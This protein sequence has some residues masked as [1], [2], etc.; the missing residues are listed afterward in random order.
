MPSWQMR[1]SWRRKVSVDTITQATGLIVFVLWF[2]RKSKFVS[3]N[4][5]HAFRISEWNAACTRLSTR[6]NLASTSALPPIPRP[7]NPSG[8]SISGPSASVDVTASNASKRSAPDDASPNEGDSSMASPS[9]K[10]AKLSS[11][12]VSA[13]N[14]TPVEG[15]TAKVGEPASSL[16]AV[17]AVAAAQQQ[18]TA[19]IAL[20]VLKREDLEP[21]K[22]PSQKEMEAALL[23]MRKKMLLDQYGI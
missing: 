14:S 10:E 12:S 18:A 20:N 15:L 7:S 6:L 21:P 23:V 5:G 17:A 16:P 4:V 13:S 19:Y 3:D 11:D 8:S 1:P 22:L 9:A 2:F